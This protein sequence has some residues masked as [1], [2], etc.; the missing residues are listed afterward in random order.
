M[1]GL[2][3]KVRGDSSKRVG[4]FIGDECDSRAGDEVHFLHALCSNGHARDSLHASQNV[5][6][7]CTGV[8]H[9]S[10]S[11]GRDLSSNRRRA[12]CEMGD[13]SAFSR[14]DR[15]MA[16]REQGITTI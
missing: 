6:L 8:V 1:L 2:G 11:V 9:R 14:D 3:Q 4:V 5:D 12:G 10:K 16:R 15:R 7:V 13:P